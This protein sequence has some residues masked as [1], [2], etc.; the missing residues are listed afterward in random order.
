MT[1]KVIKVSRAQVRA[2]QLLVEHAELF[3]TE[4]SPAIRAMAQA[5]PAKKS[6]E[7][8]S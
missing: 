4:V 7:A 3:G 6:D 8:K 2:A 5:K 1:G